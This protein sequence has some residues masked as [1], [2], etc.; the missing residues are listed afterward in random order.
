MSHVSAPRRPLAAILV[1][2]LVLP[3]AV[4]AM[5]PSSAGIVSVHEDDGSLRDT[6]RL[7]RLAAPA[8]SDTRVVVE[9]VNVTPR[10][11]VPSIGLRVVTAGG[12]LEAEATRHLRV[13]HDS[14]VEIEAEGVESGA[15]V[16]ASALRPPG[17]AAPALNLSFALDLS[18]GTHWLVVGTEDADVRYHVRIASDHYGARVDRVGDA[19]TMYRFLHSDDRHDWQVTRRVSTTGAL[20]LE[21]SA[22]ILLGHPHNAIAMALDQDA[23]RFMLRV[24]PPHEGPCTA[25]STDAAVAL[26]EGNAVGVVETA[27][28]APA[29]HALQAD[30]TALVVEASARPTVA[31]TVWDL[32][33]PVP[34]GAEA[35]CAPPPQELPSGPGGAVDEE[36]WPVGLDGDVA[37]VLP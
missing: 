29:M 6:D 37:A 3:A 20:H 34:H 22:Q 10:G 4:L 11:P 23:S 17:S 12:V 15:L 32:G 18:P 24:T 16:A 33:L 31:A 26:V 8:G 27:W 5:H 13:G 28:T 30:V 14:V 25:S 21:A 2:L 7:F 9:V 1:A 36:A 19:A 35:L